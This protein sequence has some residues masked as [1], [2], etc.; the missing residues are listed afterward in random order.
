MICPGWPQ[1]W[2]PPPPSGSPVV[3]VRGVCHQ[4]QLVFMVVF[5]P[6]LKLNKTKEKLSSLKHYCIMKI[7]LGG[8]KKWGKVLGNYDLALLGLGFPDQ[9][10]IL[11][12]VRKS[13]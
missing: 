5:L 6:Q 4:A 3:G 8:T 9:N 10:V 1:T 12:T 13:G 11:W 2:N 7:F